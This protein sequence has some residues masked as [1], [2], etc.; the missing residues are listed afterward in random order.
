VKKA[1][2]QKAITKKP[3]AKKAI[4]KKPRKKKTAAKK[5]K[6][7]KKKVVRVLKSAGKKP[8]K[9]WK[10]VQSN[11]VDLLIK[12][13]GNNVCI[14]YLIGMKVCS[15]YVPHICVCSLC[16]LMPKRT[17]TLAFLCVLP[18]RFG[19]VQSKTKGLNASR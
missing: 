4:A 2:A 1:P 18:S 13:K 9:R 8:A 6:P 17:L 3:L 15:L 14:F 5:P 7:A 11:N 16:V 10:R 12:V 19:H